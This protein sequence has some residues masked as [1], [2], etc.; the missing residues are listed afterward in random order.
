MLRVLLHLVDE[1][2]PDVALYGTVAKHFLLISML[3]DDL[4]QNFALDELLIVD[5]T[6]AK[7]AALVP[8]GHT[9]WRRFES[10]AEAEAAYRD[11]TWVYFEHGGER[12][13]RFEH[14]T[15]NVIY[16]FGPDSTGFVREPG[17][18]YVEIPTVRRHGF[19]SP[20][21]ASIALYDRHRR[22]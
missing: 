21:A 12:L 8:A 5:E 1:E 2:E 16:A 20:I 17:K 3:W 15:G 19:F 13:D 6:T 18:T 22:T 14:P 11:A 7:L 4:V 9:G 10:L